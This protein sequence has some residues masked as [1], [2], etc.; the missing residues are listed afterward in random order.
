[1]REMTFANDCANCCNFHAKLM[2]KERQILRFILQNL[3]KSFANMETLVVL[4]HFD[5]VNLVLYLHYISP[6]VGIINAVNII[7]CILSRGLT[8]HTNKCFNLTLN[9]LLLL[10]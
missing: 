3:R 9:E 6:I 8:E 2:C 7:I 5:G 10:F 1:M 4:I